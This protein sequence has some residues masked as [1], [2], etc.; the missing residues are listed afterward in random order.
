MTDKPFQTLGILGGGQLGRMSA[1]AASRLGIKCVVYTDGEDH[2][3]SHVAA[4]TY[5]GAYDDAEKLKAFAQDVDV[6]TYEFE[7]IPLET[8]EILSKLKPIYPDHK[9]LEVAQN[10]IAEKTYLNAIS[11]PTTRWM[12]IETAADLKKCFS[13]W[14][15]ENLIIKT[16]R[17][18]YD[19]KGQAKIEKSDDLDRAIT[20]FG[21]QEI[22]AEEIVDFECEISVI[23]AR[24]KDGHVETYGPVENEHKNH[25]LSVSKCPTHIPSPI[26]V[27]AAVLTEK[28]ASELNLR[29][30]LTLEF[31]VT[32]DGQLLANEIA[33]RTHNSGH[34]TIDACT[35]SQFENHVRTVCGL[36][37]GMPIQHSNARMIN[38][39]G[40]DVEDVAGYLSQPKT[41]VHLYGKAETRAGRKMG[42]VTIL[43]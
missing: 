26:K 8:L 4:K 40:D 37:V 21:E 13:E 17:F 43:A 23:V 2:P 9:L 1:V 27:R 31:F 14:D 35:V 11:I 12:K 34:W 24:D 15:C 39:I 3:A 33:P 16:T 41:C 20:Q 7:N 5:V 32:K 38:L 18:G 36:P 42:H 28:L 25:I 10:R 30:V 22:I 19:G 6:V 29:G